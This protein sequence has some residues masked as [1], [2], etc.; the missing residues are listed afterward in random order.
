M[1]GYQA[2]LAAYR[3][4]ARRLLA[5]APTGQQ[6]ARLERQ[7]AECVLRNRAKLLIARLQQTGDDTVRRRILREVFPDL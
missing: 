1:D 7:F 6:R 4:Q 5:A 2:V 3:A